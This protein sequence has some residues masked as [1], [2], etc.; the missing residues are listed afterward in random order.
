MRMQGPLG[1]ESGPFGCPSCAVTIVERAVRATGRL[2]PCKAS[3]SL[4]TDRDQP[5]WM[6]PVT[7]HF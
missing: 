6:Q 5:T 2:K 7:E 1:L 3:Q 4:T